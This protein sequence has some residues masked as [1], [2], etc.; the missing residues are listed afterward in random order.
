[1]SRW[2]CRVASLAFKVPETQFLSVSI[3]HNYSIGKLLDAASAAWR[4]QMRLHV[5]VESNG[6]ESPA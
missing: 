3:W 2:T 1:M 6:A 4:R 5:S